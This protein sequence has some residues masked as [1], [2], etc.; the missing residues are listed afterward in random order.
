M[1]PELVPPATA[2]TPPDKLLAIAGLMPYMP[3][4]TRG[5]EPRLRYGLFW[6]TSRSG[7]PNPQFEKDLSDVDYA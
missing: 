3:T 1:G 4:R 5:R 7:R 6:T 2:P